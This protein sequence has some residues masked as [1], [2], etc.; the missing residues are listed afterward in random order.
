MKTRK[1]K[2]IEKRKKN[3]RKSKTIVFVMSSKNFY[4]GYNDTTNDSRD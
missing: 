4:T 2:K 3:Q 1:S